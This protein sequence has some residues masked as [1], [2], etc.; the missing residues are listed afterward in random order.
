MLFATVFAHNHLPEYMAT[1]HSWARI[2][3]YQNLL[4]QNQHRPL[5]TDAKTYGSTTADSRDPAEYQNG[6][7]HLRNPGPS[8]L[9]LP[10]RCILVGDQDEL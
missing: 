8:N 1:A 7:P 5:V 10:W 9:H 6:S 2:N 4:I 3:T